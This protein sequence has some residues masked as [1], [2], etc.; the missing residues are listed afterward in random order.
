VIAALFSAGLPVATRK[1][2]SHRQRGD[3]SGRV[4]D[5]AIAV[6]HCRQILR[7]ERPLMRY[8]I[9]DTVQDADQEAVPIANLCA[10]TIASLA[11]NGKE[12]AGLFNWFEVF[13]TNL[14]NHVN[15]VC[16][17]AVSKSTTP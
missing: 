3:Q 1:G 12:C 9:R 2:K 6:N 8:S 17:E 7:K 16:S 11:E 10:R 4:S 15:R 14:T 13:Q 5:R